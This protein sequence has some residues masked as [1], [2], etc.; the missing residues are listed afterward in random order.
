[1]VL[2]DLKL[3]V[4][5]ILKNETIFLIDDELDNKAIDLYLKNVITQRNQ[6]QKQKE[7]EK[8][9]PQTNESKYSL[10]E[11]ICQKM[12]FET[13]EDLIKKL[14]ELE[15]KTIHELQSINNEL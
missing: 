5:T 3:K 15:N 4:E 12:E 8:L 11:S 9:Q 7:Q 10:I 6:I 2:N 1:M 13:K 14:E